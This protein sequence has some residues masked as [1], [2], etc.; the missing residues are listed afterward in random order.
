MNY[1][2]KYKYILG[3]IIVIIIIII[4]GYSL[5]SKSKNNYNG[6]PRLETLPVTTI[7]WM[8]YTSPL[9]FSFMYPLNF[10]VEESDTT[11]K[12][13]G[14]LV[15]IEKFNCKNPHP[16]KIITNKTT[17][18]GF[19]AQI[20]EAEKNAYICNNTNTACLDIE[21]DPNYI[22]IFNKTKITE[23]F[24][25]SFISTLNIKDDFNK[26]KCLK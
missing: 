4:L 10:K 21:K 18:Y 16:S 26:I 22:E 15:N 6:L 11:L 23:G 9:G 5:I 17:L 14:I 24:F 12:V 2:K 3:V 1:I 7:D 25:H 8:P 20:N 19:P 13:G